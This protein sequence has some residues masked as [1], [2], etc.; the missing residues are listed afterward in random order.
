MTAQQLPQG[1][2]TNNSFF[3]YLLLIMIVVF[4]GGCITE[5]ERRGYSSLPQNRPADWEDRPYG[6]LRN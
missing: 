1:L 4:A 6:D 3:I 2:K 5:Q